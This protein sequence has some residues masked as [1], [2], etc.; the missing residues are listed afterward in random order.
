V[1]AGTGRTVALLGMR[2]VVVVDTADALLVCPRERAQQ[3]RGIVDELK[4]RGDTD[5]C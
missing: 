2:D 4:S 1:V 5:L 3:V